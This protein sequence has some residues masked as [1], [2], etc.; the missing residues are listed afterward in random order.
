MVTHPTLAGTWTLLAASVLAA[1]AHAQTLSGAVLIDALRGGGYVLLMRHASSPFAPPAPAAAEPGNTKP[2]RQLDEA[3]KTS[4]RAMGEAWRKLGIPVGQVLSS[5]TFRAL[6]TA[7]LESLPTPTTFPE[8]GDGGQ[9][10]QAVNGS[11]GVWLRAKVAEP[12]K[13]KTDTV[14]ITHVP[15]IRAAYAADSAGLA[16]GEAMIFHPD[17]HGGAQLEGRVKIE[18]WPELAR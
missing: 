2:E 15:N 18:T 12:P 8:L 13:G 3:G 5:P 4:A 14:I 7:R 6:Q 1:S 17:G 10:M 9:S 11:E 16:D